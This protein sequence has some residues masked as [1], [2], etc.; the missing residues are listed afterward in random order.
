[1]T[2]KE[3]LERLNREWESYEADVLDQADTA[4]ANAIS[5][6]LLKMAFIGGASGAL[7]VLATVFE[8]DPA[9]GLEFATAL[10]D[11]SRKM[12]GTPTDESK[13]HH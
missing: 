12:E 2:G 4:F 1:M 7:I 10:A 8:I 3:F 5:R 6:D 11:D 9:K 13:T